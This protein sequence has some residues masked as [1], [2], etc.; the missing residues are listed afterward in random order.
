MVLFNAAAER[1]FGCTEM[2][3]IG[4]PL[5]RFIPAR[6]RTFVES[7]VKRGTNGQ[8]DN[9]TGRRANNQAF[10][11]EASI[12]QTMASGTKLFT[13][14]LRDVTE[15]K[16]LEAQLRQAQ[17]ME[18][19]GQLASGVAHDFNNLLMVIFGN[20]ELLEM[21]L[22]RDAPQRESVGQI[23]RAAESAAALTRQLLAFGRKQV[24]ELSIV[25]LNALVTDA[26][27]MLRRLLGEMDDCK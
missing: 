24:P 7:A 20:G 4:Q 21:S 23:S 15:R 27:K 12:S 5:E 22:P 8:L 25:D 9:L 3:A 16:H 18:A 26:E 1:M 13:L 17:K 10:P 11:I 14:F 6:L 2:E 19:L